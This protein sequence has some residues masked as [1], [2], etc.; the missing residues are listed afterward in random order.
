MATDA[1]G[2]VQPASRKPARSRKDKFVG[3][4]YWTWHIPRGPGGPNDNTKLIATAKDGKIDWPEKGCPHHWGEPELGYYMMTDPFVIRKHASML[5]DAGVDVVFFDTTNAAFTW[6]DEYEALCRVYTE[7]RAE[8]NR[9]PVDRLHL[10][11]WQ[12]HAGAQQR[13]ERSLPAGTW[14]DLWFRGRANR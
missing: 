4:F 14:S 7:M 11:V 12:S 6:K 3:I 9:D 2:R 1:L 13:L 10:S 8:G 5:V